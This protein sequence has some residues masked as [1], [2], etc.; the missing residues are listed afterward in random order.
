MALILLKSCF[1]LLGANNIYSMYSFVL[2]EF[3]ILLMPYFTLFCLG[4][5]N[6]D[7]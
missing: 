6:V 4:N 1:I 7:L 5:E 2:F 3:C